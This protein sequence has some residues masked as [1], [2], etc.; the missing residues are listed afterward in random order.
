MLSLKAYWRT[1]AVLILDMA[2]AGCREIPRVEHETDREWTMEDF[3]GVL[4][5]GL[6]GYRNFER[7]QNLYVSQRCSHCH[8]LS[9]YSPAE[10]RGP[11]LKVS[12][13]QYT[14]EEA[15]SH[16]LT[17]KTHRVGADFPLRHLDQSQILD[18]LAYI[19]SGANKASPFFRGVE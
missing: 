19:L 7:G 11:S 15:L 13:L 6:E 1:L 16:I 14:P 5:V 3:G 2:L 8:A 9:D 17:A 18:L 4:S 12:A 10:H